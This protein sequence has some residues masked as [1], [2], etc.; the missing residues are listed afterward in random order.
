MFEKQRK[1]KQLNTEK[2]E[3]E[4][5]EKE[6]VKKKRKRKQS[7]SSSSSSSLMSWKWL[8]KM[9][10]KTTQST[11]RSRKQEEEARNVGHCHYQLG[12]H[13]KSVFDNFY[14]YRV[15]NFG[16]FRTCQFLRTMGTKFAETLCFLLFD[17]IRD[18]N[19]AKV[20]FFG[21]W[22]HW[23]AVF[24]E[25]R[26]CHFLRTL[27]T[28]NWPIPLLSIS[29]TLGIQFWLHLRPLNLFLIGRY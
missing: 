13:K 8:A 24:S 17:N 26:F 7:T 16:N 20:S 14:E 4:K 1:R 5:K 23:E 18:Q 15:P 22:E 11:T 25:F 19:F 21:F 29:W 6:N 28:N 10:I 12:V 27:G 3:E 2:A 9:K